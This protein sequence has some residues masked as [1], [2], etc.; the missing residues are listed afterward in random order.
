[1]QTATTRNSDSEFYCPLLDAPQDVQAEVSEDTCGQEAGVV[2]VHA[3]QQLVE[4]GNQ[5]PSEGA[6]CDVSENAK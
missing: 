3:Y 6:L 4:E 1:V 2:T 5:R